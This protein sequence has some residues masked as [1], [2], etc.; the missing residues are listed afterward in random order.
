VT[1]PGFSEWSVTGIRLWGYVI[2][3]ILG[4]FPIIQPA[5]FGL[6]QMLGRVDPL[7]EAMAGVRSALSRL[8]RDIRD[9][10]EASNTDRMVIL[11]RQGLEDL[12]LGK[13]GQV[14]QDVDLLIRRAPATY[15][16]FQERWA[17][18]LKAINN[19]PAP[20]A[21]ITIHGFWLW[22]R[23]AEVAA[24]VQAAGR[25]L[26]LGQ[27]TLTA[28]QLELQKVVMEHAPD[29]VHG[30][31]YGL[32]SVMVCQFFLLEVV[33][34]I[35]RPRILFWVALGLVTFNVVK[36]GLFLR[37]ATQLWPVRNEVLEIAKL[38]GVPSLPRYAFRLL[39]GHALGVATMLLLVVRFLAL[40]EALQ[41]P[42]N[43]L[44][45]LHRTILWVAEMYLVLAQGILAGN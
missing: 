17:S 23:S 37:D 4:W 3:I 14:V 45:G 11:G 26:G 33:F 42:G 1:P 10:G 41:R 16:E 15:S 25:R 36:L 31:L 39:V 38:A 12:L 20:Q 27:N 9:L 43:I 34:A 2:F 30:F 21:I 32:Y 24:V 13:F 22:L 28:R 35:G 44:S 40:G 6:Q 7:A 19:D 18:Q 29:L 5:W 8:F